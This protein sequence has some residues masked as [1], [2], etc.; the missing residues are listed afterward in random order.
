[1]DLI[2]YSD[3]YELYVVKQM[4]MWKISQELNVAVGT[5]FNYLKK[6]N[7]R[8][9]SS[10]EANKGRKLSP[11]HRLAIS[12]RMKGFK[13]SDETRK[14]MSEAK[15]I[16]RQ[17]H[18]KRRCDGYI[19]VYYPDHPKSTKDGYI[20]EHILV[21]EKSIG[22]HLEENECV[23]HINENREDNRIENLKL[24]TKSEHMSYHAKKRWEAKNRRN[25]L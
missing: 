18:K 13:H 24:M 10:S 9:R 4:P 12:R 11:E 8:T 23:H 3:I 7:I 2:P 6:Y 22:R 1:M 15:K 20:M 21:V 17:G 25:G 16:H 5:V 14:K 19:A